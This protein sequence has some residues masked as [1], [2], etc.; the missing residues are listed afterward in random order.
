MQKNQRR[1]DK[2]SRQENKLLDRL[3]QTYSM[4]AFEPA[5]KELS[6]DIALDTEEKE[7]EEEWI[8]IEKY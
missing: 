5:A 3:N 8:I 2:L 4:F 1:A 7:K 6:R